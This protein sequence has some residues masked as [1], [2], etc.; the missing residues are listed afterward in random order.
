M[1]KV[2][3]DLDN[4]AEGVFNC[5]LQDSSNAGFR[6]WTERYLERVGEK[7]HYQSAEN[8]GMYRGEPDDLGAGTY[9]AYRHFTAK[10]R[11]QYRQ[12][13]ANKYPSSHRTGQGRAVGGFERLRP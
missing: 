1:K 11:G 3:E 10:N 6:G 12:V 7:G 8:I 4:G 13:K 5:N 2:V 9:A